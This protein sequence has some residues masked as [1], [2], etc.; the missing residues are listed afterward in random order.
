MLLAGFF[1][2]F[3]RFPSSAHRQ[4]QQTTALERNRHG[5]TFL[6]LLAALAWQSRPPRPHPS[7]LAFRYL[8]DIVQFV[9]RSTP[10]SWLARTLQPQLWKW[11]CLSKQ[12]F[13]LL[14]LI[15]WKK[16]LSPSRLCATTITYALVTT[17]PQFC[18][19]NRLWV[20]SAQRGVWQEVL[21]R[22][23]NHENHE[24]EW[25]F[26]FKYPSFKIL[27]STLSKPREHENLEM[28]LLKTTLDTKHVLALRWIVGFLLW[29]SRKT[30]PS[31]SMIHGGD[32]HILR[33]SLGIF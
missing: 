10:T 30:P 5:N 29:S 8:T 25:Y 31:Y 22:T 14:P 7:F 16:L 20:R 11:R 13:I 2:W 27:Q 6:L 24:I 17:S 12:R 1:W 9:C 33:W 3:L 21:F 18:R 28:K 15:P 23:G 32:N 26:V 19:L 4:C